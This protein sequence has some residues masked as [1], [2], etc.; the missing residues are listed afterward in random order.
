VIPA[1]SRFGSRWARTRSSV[2]SALV[3]LLPSGGGPNGLTTSRAEGEVWQ[4]EEKVV[5]AA[6]KIVPADAEAIF[7]AAL[8][9]L[10][11]AITLVSRPPSLA[12]ESLPHSAAEYERLHRAE[13]ARRLDVHKKLAARH[14]GLLLLETLRGAVQALHA[15]VR[16]Q[17][18]ALVRGRLTHACSDQF[19]AFMNDAELAVAQLGGDPTGAAKA[20]W[21][22]ARAFSDVKTRDS[23]LVR[24]AELETA[25]RAVQSLVGVRFR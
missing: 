13:D 22:H 8:K 23:W 4:P 11:S 16:P 7:R 20:I 3:R 18:A 14:P 21:Q 5:L 2:A 17:S 15:R 19:F 24:V 25:Y 6:A 10:A 9:Q 1:R 12:T